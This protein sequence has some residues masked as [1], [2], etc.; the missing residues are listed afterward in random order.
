MF[1]FDY[2]NYQEKYFKYFVRPW[3]FISSSLRLFKYLLSTLLFLNLLW[4][5]VLKCVELFL[6]NIFSE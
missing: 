2:C 1:L 3:N 5:Y 4:F 6:S